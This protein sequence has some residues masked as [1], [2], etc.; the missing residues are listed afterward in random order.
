[1]KRNIYRTIHN[2]QGTEGVWDFRRGTAFD[3]SPFPEV[4]KMLLAAKLKD[5][6]HAGKLS[7]CEADFGFQNRNGHRHQE[8]DV[9]YRP[10]KIRLNF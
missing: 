3:S 1:M 4:T 10:I 5:H 2:I 6:S 8:R 9:C 7:P